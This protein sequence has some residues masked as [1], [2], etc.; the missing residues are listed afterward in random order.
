MAPQRSSTLYAK[1]KPDWTSLADHTRHVV[2]A[3]EAAATALGFD[4]ELARKGAVLHDLGKAHPVFQKRLLQGKRLSDQRVFRHE[5]A[6][7]GFLPAFPEKDHEALIEMIAAH[8]KSIQKDPGMKG[9]LDIIDHDENVVFAHLDGWDEWSTGSLEVL[10]QLGYQTP[11]ISHED[12]SQALEKVCDYVEHLERGMSPWKGLLMSADHFASA[13]IGKTQNQIKGLFSTPILDAYKRQSE[14]YPLS[15]LPA[16][17]PKPHTFVTAPTGAG[18]TDYLMRRCRGRIFYTLPFQASINAMFKRFENDLREDNPKA[19]IRLLHSTSRIQLNKNKTEE[20]T[21]QGLMGASIKVLTPHQLGSLVFGSRAYE[22]L[23]VDLEGCDVVL[24]E[25]HTYSGTS[26]AI[27]FEIIKILNHLGCRLHIGTATMPSDLKHRIINVLGS[28][29]VH[30]VELSSEILDT[31]DRHTVHCL[32][33][34]QE[35]DK[36]ISE[37]FPAINPGK[38]K[39]LLVCNQVKRA[40]DWC[41]RIA[42][43][44]P[45]VK[46][47]LIHSR[48]TRRHRKIKEALLQK[49]DI[50]EKPCIVIATQVVEVS[51]D[52]SFDRLIT[53]AAPMDALIQ[54]FGRINRRRNSQTMGKLKPVHILPASEDDK[55]LLPYDAGIVRQSLAQLPQSGPLK[56]RVVQDKIDAVYPEMIPWSLDSNTIY[57]NGKWHLRKLEHCSRAVLLQALEIDGAIAIRESDQD[58]YENAQYEQRINME[59]PVRYHAIAHRNLDQSQESNKPFIVPDLAYSSAMGLMM[60][61]CDPA[62]Y[63]K[64]NQIL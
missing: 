29:H 21:L 16:D 35:A 26:Q 20:K 32:E 6:S 19:H 59:I 8:H 48:Y 46:S 56:E 63:N 14:W 12:A 31:F 55:A 50:S 1:G 4:V 3:I 7:L 33:D 22:A 25:I 39:L 45:D 28:E 15:E 57:L 64:A 11:R 41:E 18:K 44:Y 9:L 53:E 36:I 24:D 54:R 27:V 37:A 5:I 43:A 62:N 47:M 10:H 60:E 2:M 17:S 13:L 49:W 58:A 38:E 52:I 40:Q 34:D 23:A 30:E 42:K 61:L 51:L